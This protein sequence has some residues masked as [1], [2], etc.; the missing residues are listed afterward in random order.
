MN[1]GWRA[2]EQQMSLLKPFL[3][4]CLLCPTFSPKVHQVSR[5]ETNVMLRHSQEFHWRSSAFCKT[6][7]SLLAIKFRAPLNSAWGRNGIWDERCKLPGGVQM[8]LRR[9]ESPRLVPVP[10]APALVL[11]AVRSCQRCRWGLEPKVVL[12]SKCVLCALLLLGPKTF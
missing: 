9:R 8:G 7:E 1:S 12:K 6:S 5:V 10:A 3:M 11:A 4:L 2:L